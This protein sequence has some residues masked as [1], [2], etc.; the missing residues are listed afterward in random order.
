MS[1][2]NT[3]NKP[4]SV[5]RAIQPAPRGPV[6]LWKPEDPK[7]PKYFCSICPLPSNYECAVCHSARWCSIECHQTDKILH[8]AYCTYYANFIR[9]NPRPANSTLAFHFGVNDE[10]PMLIWMPHHPNTKVPKLELYF[11]RNHLGSKTLEESAYRGFKIDHIVAI[12]YTNLTP[13]NLMSVPF[14]KAIG[15]L[16]EIFP[17]ANVWRG[18]FVIMSGT[19]YGTAA[20]N[21]ILN[22]VPKD[23]TLAH[24]RIAV[25]YFRF[26]DDPVDLAKH[27]P[28]RS[29]AGKHKVM[30][31]KIACDAEIKATGCMK[32]TSIK[33]P[34]DHPVFQLAPS[35]LPAALGLP[36]IIDRYPNQA[37]WDQDPKFYRDERIGTMKRIIDPDDPNWGHIE[38]EWEGRVESI[39]VVRADKRDVYVGQ[40]LGLIQFCAGY[41]TDQFWF[42]PKDNADRDV[43]AAWMIQNISRV[44]FEAFFELFIRDMLQYD[45]LWLDVKSPY[46]D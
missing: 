30:G 26:G 4:T 18:D 5:P 29:L 39:L 8:D 36:F 14:N 3:R 23:I 28:L 12:Y 11:D 13:N 31:V 20:E 33:L 7:D 9:N 17:M 41:L 40:L 38:K 21:Q 2:P 37:G 32:Y 35:P 6:V 44:H 16:V 34:H 42:G 10:L 22:P 1:K 27:L 25:D 24:L 19:K 43:K 45:Q 15:T 46:Y